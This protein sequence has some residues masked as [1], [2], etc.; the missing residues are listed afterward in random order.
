MKNNKGYYSWIH[1]MKNA[2]MESQF[3]GHKMLNEQIDPNWRPD[4]KAVAGALQRP[5]EAPVINPKHPG[6]ASLTPE[7][8]F[9]EIK[10]GKIARG[11]ERNLTRNLKGLAKDM[12]PNKPVA[13]DM[14]PNN[15]DMDGDGDGEAD[16][17]AMLAAAKTSFVSPSTSK[18]SAIQSGAFP[19]SPAQHPPAQFPTPE[20]AAAE[21]RRLNA[22]SDA[23]RM[24]Q[25]HQQEATREAT[26]AVEAARKAGHGPRGQRAA[27]EKAVAAYKE[28]QLQEPPEESEEVVI[29]GQSLAMPKIQE[30][31]NNIIGRLLN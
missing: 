30:S 20:A 10:T 1:A 2:A 11:D 19:P 3:K 29:D 4:F 6:D 16:E 24:R 26:A 8:I 25:I 14:N 5:G 22:P 13:R 12:D 23:M 31:I 9:D 28:R 7:Q 27:A 21:V 18:L 15:A 17:V